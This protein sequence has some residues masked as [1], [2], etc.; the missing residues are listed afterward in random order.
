MRGTRGYGREYRY[1]RGWC[2]CRRWRC[3]NGIEEENIEVDKEGVIEQDERKNELPE[4]TTTKEDVIKVGL[5]ET[6]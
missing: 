1:L 4:N 6:M 5:T 2:Y 3:G